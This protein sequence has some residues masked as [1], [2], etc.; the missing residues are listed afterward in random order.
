MVF[1]VGHVAQGALPKIVTLRPRNA[2]LSSHGSGRRCNGGLKRSNGSS[3]NLLT[4]RAGISFDAAPPEALIGG[5]VLILGSATFLVLEAVKAMKAN[6]LGAK[7]NEADTREKEAPLPRQDAF[8]VCQ[9]KSNEGWRW[10]DDH[11]LASFNSDPVQIDKDF[12]VH[13]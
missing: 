11:T 3:R 9:R 4:V 13:D 2:L 1:R 6:E 8:L 10:H 12:I 5:A 7:F